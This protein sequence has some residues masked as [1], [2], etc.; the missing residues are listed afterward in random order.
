M[1]KNKFIHLLS[2]KSIGS[3]ILVFILLLTIPKISQYINQN[4]QGNGKEKASD[5]QENKTIEKNLKKDP[6]DQDK[7]QNPLEE[8][9]SKDIE[10]TNLKSSL[11]NLKTENTVSKSTPI[12]VTY[13]PSQDKAL[14]EEKKEPIEKTE[15]EQINR[16]E[17][18]EQEK[19]EN[20]ENQEEQEDS[21]DLPLEEDLG[22]N[23]PEKEEDGDTMPQDVE[24]SPPK[25]IALESIDRDS[26]T[27]AWETVA[28]AEIYRIY[29]RQQGQDI[30]EKIGT[31]GENIFIDRDVALS[32]TYWY[33]ISALNSKGEGEKSEIYEVTMAN[34]IGNTAGNLNENAY[35]A[36]QGD[37]V[38]YTNFQEGNNLYK[39]RI[40]GRDNTKLCDKKAGYINVI[41]EWIYFGQDQDKGIY[42]I[43]TDGTG[44]TKL[45]EDYGRYINI[46][47]KD[48]YYRNESDQ[49][50]IYTMKIDGTNRR[51]INN[52]ASSFINIV[53]DWVYYYANGRKE[54]LK[55]KKDGSNLTKIY[56]GNLALYLGLQEDWIYYS[57]WDKDYNLYRININGS[58]NKLINPEKSKGIKIQGDWV[59]YKSVKNGDH[60]YK[61][62]TDGSERTKV[63]EGPVEHFYLFEDWIFYSL[64]EDSTLYQVQI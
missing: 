21:G 28:Y 19:Q 2:M 13:N 10:K 9:S 56:E 47:G 34:E 20:Q 49:D 4:P 25:K 35:V 58:Q 1:K 14:E 29:R 32:T 37:W 33:R 23:Q 52:T 63:V 36:L 7:G 26:F 45:T 18:E 38:Y 62:K 5:V 57:N 40:N 15:E 46:R 41:G 12:I 27:I 48:L 6:G 61:I 55:I 53:G 59:Y 51:K 3:I 43:K 11:K 24:P 50:K 16:E 8:K 22:P 60:L 44:L 54:I 17:Q 42:K 31:V 30:W 39:R 64:Q